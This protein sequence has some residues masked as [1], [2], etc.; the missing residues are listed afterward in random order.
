MK[1]LIKKSFI[2][3]LCMVF[4]ILLTSC[5]ELKQEPMPTPEQTKPS[6]SQPT[7]TPVPTLA[8]TPVP[9]PFEIP[10]PIITEQGIRIEA[11]NY[12]RAKDNTIP[13]EGKR[14][15]TNYDTDFGVDIEDCWLGSF[16]TGWVSGGEWLEYDVEIPQAGTYYIWLGLAHDA[17]NP[18]KGRVLVNG[19]PVGDEITID[20]T[21]PY[22]VEHPPGHW[23]TWLNYEAGSVY[24]DSGLNVIKLL[25]AG[26]TAGYN[27][28]FIWLG[29]DPGPPPPLSELTPVY[30]PPEYQKP[31]D[32]HGD[33]QVIG[34]DLCDSTGNPIQLKGLTSHDLRWL[35]LCRDFTIPRTAYDLGI[36]I[37][38]VSLKVSAIE[39][40]YMAPGHR[41][42]LKER[43]IAYID[44]AIEAGIY[45]II[46]WHVWLPMDFNPETITE[47]VSFF[48]EMSLRYAAYPNVIYE[49]CSDPNAVTW[50]EIKSYADQVI[51]V[52]RINDPD[53]IIITGTPTFSQDIETASQD[54]L[55]GYNNVMYALHFAAGTD[56]AEMRITAEAALTNGTPIFVTS[57]LLTNT[58]MQF[59]D[60]TE[61]QI[62][63]DWMEENNVSWI[64]FSMS[65]KNELASI[66]RES[67]G[68]TGPW[69]IPYDFT[70][71]GIWISNQFN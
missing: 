30:P 4:C 40:G 35:W 52:I 7:E 54:P 5:P 24:L 17:E 31:I 23:Q 14:Y 38:R 58:G 39:Y 70:E 50:A 48:N 57:W 26:V 20:N 34:K 33:L 25:H 13:N 55:L 47:A 67:A 44:D 56:K 63:V 60:Y 28:D 3:V 65:N 68:F 1:I 15:R 27:V 71:G 18:L 16:N 62:W 10:P 53:N 45:V 46:D 9:T 41:E 8:P 36:D 32:V 19:S 61:S 2:G 66:L 37:F 43:V 64:N 42:V 59:Y 22:N 51:P 29:I 11:E 12:N 6:I 21:D 49:I 69:N